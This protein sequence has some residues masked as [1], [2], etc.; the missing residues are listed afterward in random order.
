MCFI[1]GVIV[2]MF[3]VVRIYAENVGRPTRR[4][5]RRTRRW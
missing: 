5:K 4:R 2:A 1:L 3:P